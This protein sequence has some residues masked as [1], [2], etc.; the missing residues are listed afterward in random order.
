MDT[1]TNQIRVPVHVADGGT[2]LKTILQGTLIL[3]TPRV[4][5]RASHGPASWN[6][7]ESPHQTKQRKLGSLS[8]PIKLHLDLP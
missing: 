1:S 2:L 3:T 8:A 6:L 4:S 7:M 5:R